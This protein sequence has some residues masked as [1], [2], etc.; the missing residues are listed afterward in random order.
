MRHIALWGN[1]SEVAQGFAVLPRFR[2]AR[3]AAFQ[4]L[5][6]TSL[7]HGIA[8]AGRQ[9]AGPSPHGLNV[10]G[11]AALPHDNRMSVR[12]RPAELAVTDDS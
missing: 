9:R 10:T 11:P 6:F 8:V 5:G 7:D 12:S 4:R 2:L 1:L 3:S